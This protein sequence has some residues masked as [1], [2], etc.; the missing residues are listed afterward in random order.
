MAITIDYGHSLGYV[1]QI[2]R[3]DML[4]VTGGSPTETRQLNIND[5]RVA[6]GDLQDDG[7]GMW[8]PTAFSHTPP[9]SVSG[10]TLARVVEVLT[11]YLIEFEDGLYNVN[12]VGGN[13]NVADVAI[14]NQ[15]GVN[16]ANSAG[17]QDPFA[18]QAAAFGVGEIAIDSTAPKSGTT[19][20][21]GTRAFP[22]NNVA[23][24]L[25]ISLERG[26]RT[27]RVLQPLML[28][29]N[30]FSDGYHFK[31][32]TPRTLLI[33]GEG[34]NVTNCEFFNMTV[35]GTLDGDNSLQDCIV[36]N[37]VINGG[38]LLQ[39]GLIDTVTLAGTDL[40]AILACFSGVA[41]GDPNQ[42][43]TIDLGGT[44]TSPL[45]VR[46]WH[47]GLALSNATEQAENTDVSVDMS[48]GRVLFR[49]TITDGSYLVRGMAD[50]VDDT[51][52]NATVVDL[53]INKDLRRARK[54]LTNRMTTDPTDGTATLYDDDGSP[55][56]TSTMYEDVDGTQTYRGQG[57]ERRDGFA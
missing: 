33:L 55:L 1:I 41:G 45:I 28:T 18:L 21:Y 34:A 47:G 42:V 2:P 57:A 23:D 16:T 53:T 30:D 24:A 14:K 4:D 54:H 52:E 43:A 19:F 8:A 56:E 50:V 20:P 38:I 3:A 49:N 48:S 32:D 5:L 6:L 15:V 37:L 9:L 13:S 11:P 17:L 46:D 44:H 31:G 10:V 39:C 7:A 36:T 35:T 26:I 25:A 29:S 51:G 40:T 22:V 27:I 12:I